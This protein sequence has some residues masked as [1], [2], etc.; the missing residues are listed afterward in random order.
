M[1][2]FHDSYGSFEEATQ[3]PDGLTVMSFLYSVSKH[4]NSC[5]YNFNAI[6]SFQNSQKENKNYKSFLDA[7][8]NVKRPNVTTKI[9]PPPSLN[10]LIMK[11]RTDYFTYGGSL[12]TPPCSEVVTWIEFKHTIPLTHNQVRI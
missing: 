8:N 6:D 11:E 2:F 12:T 5:I 4:S 3:H 7:V 10:D 9:E 1:V